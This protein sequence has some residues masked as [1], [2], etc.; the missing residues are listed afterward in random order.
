MAT[1][2][3]HDVYTYFPE[4]LKSKILIWVLYAGLSYIQVNAVLFYHFFQPE[5]QIKLV[6]L[7]YVLELM[8]RP[9]TT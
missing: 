9:T 3:G 4:T 1:I 6:Y 2:R 7:N 5:S 8:Y